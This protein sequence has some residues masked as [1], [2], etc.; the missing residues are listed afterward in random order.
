[1]ETTQRVHQD[2]ETRSMRNCY[3]QLR[4]PLF[5]RRVWAHSRCR[6]DAVSKQRWHVTSLGKMCTLSTARLDEDHATQKVVEC[7][8]AS[9]GGET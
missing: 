2:G 1:M 9:G 5:G 4:A 6:A 3:F 7:K 8:L